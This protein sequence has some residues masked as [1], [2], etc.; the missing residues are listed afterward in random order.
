M[1]ARAKIIP[2]DTEIASYT[3]SIHLEDPVFTPREGEK[4][5]AL[6]EWLNANRI[7]PETLPISQVIYI[8]G[9]FIQIIQFVFNRDG[10]KQLHL[11]GALNQRY[12]R[13]LRYVPV[14]KYPEEFGL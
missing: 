1:A 11:G 3:K 2:A 13:I 8:S 9:E 10:S 4:Y 12:E 7:A 5:P 6:I 14:I